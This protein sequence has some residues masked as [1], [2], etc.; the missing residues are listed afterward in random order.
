MAALQ[1]ATAAGA[2]TMSMMVSGGTPAATNPVK[3]ESKRLLKQVWSA[4]DVDDATKIALRSVEL[5]DGKG[6]HV[7]SA[8]NAVASFP[9]GLRAAVDMLLTE[10][11]TKIIQRE[12][13]E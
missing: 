5:Y 1:A 6:L 13:L 11:I 2:D 12:G 4:A 8:V 10:V 7:L 9:G 3:T